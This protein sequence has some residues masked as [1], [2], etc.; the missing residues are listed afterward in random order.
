VQALFVSVDPERDTPALLKDYVASFAPDIVGLTG[1]QGQIQTIAGEYRVYVAKQPASSGG[2]YA[3][4]HS[5]VIYVMDPNGVF[6][7]T[8]SDQTAP[9]AMAK[10]LSN[11]LG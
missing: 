5:S 7:T 4:D 11:L 9:D 1:T 2:D 10:Q 8:F 3:V 6:A